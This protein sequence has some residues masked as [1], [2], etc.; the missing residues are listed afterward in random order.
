MAK[1]TWHGR[2]I[3]ESDDIEVVEGNAYFPRSSLDPSCVRESSERRTYCHWKGFSDYLDIVV[4]GEVNEGAA[5][6]YAEPYEASSIILDRVAFWRDV[7]IKGAPEGSGLFESKPSL[8]GERSGWEAL[9]WLLSQTPKSTLTSAD[10]EADAGIVAEEVTRM[11]EVYDVQ[12]YA[13]RY[14]WQL[15]G[16]A[17]SPRLEKSS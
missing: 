6:Y 16:D 12:R 14:L 7:E 9:G 17:A 4:D 15:V 10:L 8:R 5:W 1:A 11:W 13:H 2:V 3:A